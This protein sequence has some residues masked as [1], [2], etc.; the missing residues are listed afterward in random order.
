MAIG[1]VHVTTVDASFFRRYLDAWSSGDVDHLMTFLTDDIVFRDMT[2]G[3]GASGAQKMRRF[4]EYSFASF[5]DSR[6]ELV[7]HVSDGR[8]FAM[9]WMMRPGDIPGVSFGRLVGD[10]VSEQ[11]DYWDGRRST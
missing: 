5:P 11:R 7:S 2:L 6:F 4:A 10:R 1:T 8:S 3:H 9:E